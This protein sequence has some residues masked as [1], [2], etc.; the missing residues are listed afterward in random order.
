MTKN[1]YL[2][3]PNKCKFCGNIILIKDGQRPSEVKKKKFCNSSCSSKYN[4]NKR[5]KLRESAY[6][7]V[8]N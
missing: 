6:I 1:E 4:N 5:K 2:L 8:K 3:N 7:V